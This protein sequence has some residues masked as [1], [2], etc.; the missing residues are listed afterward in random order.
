VR[1]ERFCS[2]PRDAV[3]AGAAL[4]R[5]LAL[6]TFALGE[7]L[8]QLLSILLKA[9]VHCPRPSWGL[10]HPV[11]SSYPSGH[12]TDAGTTTVALVLRRPA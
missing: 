12:A 3:W 10:A 6:V 2:R 7:A 9:L 8:A 4:R 1:A 5:L 11:G